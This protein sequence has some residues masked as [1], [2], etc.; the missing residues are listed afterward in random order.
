MAVPYTVTSITTAAIIV[1]M[2]MPAMAPAERPLLG[3]GVGATG[4]TDIPKKP[5]ASYS[6]SPL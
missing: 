6:S 4:T 2:M 3:A 5:A 1:P